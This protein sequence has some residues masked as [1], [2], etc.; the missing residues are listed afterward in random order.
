[1]TDDSWKDG[2]GQD[3]LK[4]YAEYMAQLAK[5]FVDALEG[6]GFTREEA[7]RLTISII[8]GGFKSARE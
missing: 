1:M 8:P 6:K 7:M 4:E 3:G 5:N 2:M